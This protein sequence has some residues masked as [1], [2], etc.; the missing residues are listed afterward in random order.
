[1]GWLRSV[2]SLEWQVSFAKEPYKI[3]DILQKRPVI[4][5]SL[6]IVATPYHV[7]GHIVIK[8]ICLTVD[9]VLFFFC[10][11]LV[12]FGFV[13]FNRIKERVKGI[14]YGNVCGESICIHVYS[15]IT[16]PAY[17]PMNKTL[18]HIHYPWPYIYMCISRTPHTITIDVYTYR[19]PASIPIYNTV[20]HIHYPWPYIYMCISCTPHTFAYTIILTICNTHDR[21]SIYVYGNACGEWI[22]IH[23]YSHITYPYTKPLTIYTTRDHISIYVYHVP[24][25]Q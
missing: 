2:G 11:F 21:I 15:Y 7:D 17:I 12:L 16:Y 5:R 14:V 22:C 10:F 6:L 19:F 9:T 4:W 13:L 20:D 3:D 24:R 23:I 18:E 8:R 1:M 25:I